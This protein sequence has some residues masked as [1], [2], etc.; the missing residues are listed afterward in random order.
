[1]KTLFYAALI[2]I[3][4]TGCATPGAPVYYD[5]TAAAMLQ[6]SGQML[7]PQPMYYNNP[8]IRPAMHTTCTQTA[9][10]VNCNSY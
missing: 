4:L 2:G 8:Y 1:M 7:N 6:Y 9:G 10:F 3:L 5:P